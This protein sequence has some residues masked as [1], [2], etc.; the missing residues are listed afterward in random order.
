MPKKPLTLTDKIWEKLH[1]IPDPELHIPLVEMGLIYDLKEE[2]GTVT[3]TMTLTTIGC[4]LYG[5]IQKLIEDKL[6][7]LPEVRSVQLNLT[8][9]P[10]W[11]MDMMTMEAR[12]QLGLV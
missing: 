7:E 11:S 4:P 10:P 12:M 1:E 2:N 3:V 8:F 9:D 5:T 6:R